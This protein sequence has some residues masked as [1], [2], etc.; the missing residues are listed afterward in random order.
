MHTHARL[1]FWF[2]SVYMH[3][4]ERAAVHIYVGTC[5]KKGEKRYT[6]C[7]NVRENKSFV[8]KEGHTHLS[9]QHLLVESVCRP[10]ST[11]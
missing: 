10:F 3:A 11:S 1:P 5:G 7:E 2:Y 9:K 8:F 6:D 4:C